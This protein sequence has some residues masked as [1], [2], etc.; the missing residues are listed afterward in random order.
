M[1]GAPACAAIDSATASACWAAIPPCLSGNVVMSPAAYTLISPSTR[2]Y[3]SVWTKPLPVAGIPGMRRAAAIGTD[4]T[5]SVRIARPG[6]TT[7]APF[8]KTTGVVFVRSA[9]PRSS[10]RFSSDEA[11]LGPKMRSGRRLR[12]DEGRLDLHRARIFQ[13]RLREQR[14]LVE[15]E[16]PR[17]ERVGRAKVSDRA[18]P[19]SASSTISV[20][21]VRSSGPPN[22][23]PPATPS[24]IR[25]PKARTRTS[26]SITAPSAVVALW[27]SRSRRASVPVV[28][29]AP[30]RS[31]SFR[32]GNRRTSPCW[33]GSAT[34]IGR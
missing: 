17:R 8:R 1:T 34:A 10:N 30:A 14:Q 11:I 26:H 2:P 22:V 13:R 27:S 3:W 23:S 7:S 31:T 28:N 19:A 6:T 9:M 4:T 18:R 21:A 24:R 15:R 29:R 20:I 16:R 12:C 33:K 32:R 5:R 25:T